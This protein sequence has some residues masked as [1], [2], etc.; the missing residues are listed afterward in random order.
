MHDPDFHEDLSLYSS[1]GTLRSCPP[2]LNIWQKLSRFLEVII[3][4][5]LILGFAKILAPDLRRQK[6]LEKV[7]VKLEKVKMEKE[8][9]VARLRNEHS[10]LTSDRRYMEAVARDRLNLQRDGEYVIQFER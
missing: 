8:A 5:L 10:H 2:E 4:I 6:D 7:L 3:Y 9:E 1:G